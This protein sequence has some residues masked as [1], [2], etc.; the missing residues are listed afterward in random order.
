MKNPAFMLIAALLVILVVSV[1][2]FPARTAPQPVTGW[3]TAQP[4]Q[5]QSLQ[6]SGVHA[7]V[8]AS[9]HSVSAGF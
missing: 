7:L 6:S 5:S 9:F 3:N 1:T 4:L 8:G 2:A